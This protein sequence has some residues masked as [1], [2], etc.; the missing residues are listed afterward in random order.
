MF[1][2]AERTNANPVLCVM[3]F[4]IHDLVI[5]LRPHLLY[6]WTMLLVKSRDNTNIERR[7][8]SQQDWLLKNRVNEHT[9]Q[10]TKETTFITQ[11][12]YQRA[13]W[14]CRLEMW[15]VHNLTRSAPVW[16]TVGFQRA[17][18]SLQFEPQQLARPGW[19]QKQQRL[20]LTTRIKEGPRERWWP[21]GLRPGWSNRVW[22]V[23]K[24]VVQQFLAQ[25]WE[26]GHCSSAV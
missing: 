2:A 12:G 16:C 13:V 25:F 11:M 17:V 1:E 7:C 4:S 10:T 9:Q 3:G 26:E 5:D 8:S 22:H 23:S 6:Y 21:G 24:G 19:G 18:R 20:R 15:W 14:W